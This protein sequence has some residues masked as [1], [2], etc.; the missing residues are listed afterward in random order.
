[1]KFSG[2]VSRL[3][4]PLVLLASLGAAAAE[5]T[6]AGPASGSAQGQGTGLLGQAEGILAGMDRGSATIRR[7]LADARERRDTVRMLCLDDK[8]NQIDL[9][10]RTAN[11]RRDALKASVTENDQDQAEHEFT[12]LQVLGER[13]SALVGE[14]NQCIGEEAGFAGEGRRTMVVDPSLPDVNPSV[15]PED[16]LLSEPP[17]LS[18]PIL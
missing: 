9:A 5:P 13:A 8:L 11:D 15:L 10:I 14:A 6:G 1:M 3:G 2:Q 4:A 7:Q 12:V 17:I 18:S 16:E